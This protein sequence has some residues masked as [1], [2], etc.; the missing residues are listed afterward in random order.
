MA[1]AIRLFTGSWKG[2]AQRSNRP[3]NPVDDAAC[4]RQARRIVANW[5]KKSNFGPKQEPG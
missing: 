3:V 1:Y 2:A 4:I 5:M